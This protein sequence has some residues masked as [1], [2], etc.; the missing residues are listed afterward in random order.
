MTKN[1]PCELIVS[2]IF[3][4]GEVS[5][6]PAENSGSES[7]K[8]RFDDGYDENLIGDEEDRLRLEKMTEKER[9][10]ILYSRIERREALKTRYILVVLCP[11]KIYS[12]YNI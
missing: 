12:L 9:E 4:I 2:G 11:I 7:D 3:I 6:S 8:E 1:L 5:D 10:Q